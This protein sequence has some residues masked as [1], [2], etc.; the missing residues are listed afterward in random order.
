MSNVVYIAT[1]L[2]GFIADKD[3]GLAWLESTPNPD[4]LDFGWGDFMDRMDAVVMGRS[5]FD[6]VC[7]FDCTWPYPL[8]V[9]V[10]SDSLTSLPGEYEGKAELINGSLSDVLQAIHR[11][12]YTELYI[13]GGVTVQNFL[14]EDLIDEMII[15]TIPI[16]LGRGTPLFGDLSGPREFEHVNT[17]VLLNSMV[18]SHYRRKK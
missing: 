12:G 5:T 16:L 7:G 14:K 10:L 17:E 15:T 6:T 3:G 13:D 1:S 8:P 11:K 4:K 2:D 18:K 9:F